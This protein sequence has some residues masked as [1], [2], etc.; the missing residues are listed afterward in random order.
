MHSFVQRFR[1][2]IKGVINGFDRIV[3]KGCIRS[4]VRR[5]RLDQ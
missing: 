1:D 3:F 5:L 4:E 2:K